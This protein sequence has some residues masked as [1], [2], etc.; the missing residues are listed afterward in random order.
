[1]AMLNNR[2]SEIDTPRRTLKSEGI[3][4]SRF[5]KNRFDD[6]LD[7]FAESKKTEFE[8]NIPEIIKMI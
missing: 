8:A 3:T 4:I 6:D 7:S 1:M 5:V 2:L